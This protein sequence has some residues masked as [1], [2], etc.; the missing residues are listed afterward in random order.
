MKSLVAV[1]VLLL[2]GVALATAGQDSNSGE[3]GCVLALE[4][5]HWMP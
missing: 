5:G 2:L 3:G 1:A 4:K